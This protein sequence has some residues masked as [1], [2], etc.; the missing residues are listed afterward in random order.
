MPLCPHCGGY[1]PH[2]GIC[3]CLKVK[4]TRKRRSKKK[5]DTKTKSLFDDKPTEKPDGR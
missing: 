4:D 5:A 3:S 1:Q 2:R